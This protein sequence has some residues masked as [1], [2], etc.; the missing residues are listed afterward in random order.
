MNAA[1]NE[2]LDNAE[3]EKLQCLRRESADPRG[4]GVTAYRTRSE[5]ARHGKAARRDLPLAALAQHDSTATRD[6]VGLLERQAGDRVAELVP[7]R[8][9]RMAASAFSFYRGAAAVMTDDLSHTPATGLRTQLCGD[10]HLSNFGLFATPER[11]LAFDVDD[12]DE[13][14]PGPFEWD[15][16][17][18]AASLAIAAAANGFTGKQCNRVVRACAAEYRETMTG[19]AQR[20]NLAVW[21]SRIDAAAELEA[22][23]TQLDSAQRKRTRSALQKARRRDSIQALSKLTRV[24]DGTRR[25]VSDPPLIVPIEELYTETDGESLYRDLH[26]RLDA[27]T[28]TLQ[29]DR[30]LL[31]EQYRLVQF[32]RKV[33][34]VGSVGTRTWI[35]LLLGADDGDPL[36]LQVKEASRSVL[37]DYVEGPPF[38][39]EGE[40][41]VTGQQ[42]MQS[43]SDI[44]LGW[45]RNPGPDG[46]ERDFYIRQLRD[47]KGSAVIETMAPDFMTLYGRLCGRVLAFAHARS[48]DRIAIAAYLGTGTE[49]D[50]ALTEFAATYAEQN[51]RDH[52]ELTKAIDRHRITAHTGI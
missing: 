16:K 44:F 45:T 38:T 14:Y 1:R 13:T 28:R 2:L 11:R 52:A 34:G 43:A 46:V 18:L 35:A 23:R 8:Y 36:F 48:G 22:L 32:A 10:A 40:R 9:G 17:R 37:A 27:Y 25:I 5:R 4:D 39:T 41:V 42:L 3:H 7:I 33:V 26:Q 30:R 24:V 6:P 31:I 50:Y 47:G 51:D 15:V 12:F 19:Q 21:Y 49:F 20:G 29:R